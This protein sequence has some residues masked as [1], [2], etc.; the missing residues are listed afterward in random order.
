[1]RRIDKK[2]HKN[3]RGGFYRSVTWKI[4]HA[5]V[6]QVSLEMKIRKVIIFSEAFEQTGVGLKTERARTGRQRGENGSENW[7]AGKGASCD[8]AWKDVRGAV[9]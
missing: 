7:E 3:V 5:F 4:G 6:S 1:M 9:S 8:G 2:R